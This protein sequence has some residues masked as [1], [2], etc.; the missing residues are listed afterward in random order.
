MIDPATLTI[1]EGEIICPCCVDG[2]CYVGYADCDA[3]PVN[4]KDDDE[5][6]ELAECLL[7]MGTAII[8]ENNPR[9]AWLKLP[10]D[11]RNKREAPD[12]D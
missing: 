1:G 5:E 10:Y 2:A 9:L 8:R 4:R 12:N 3:L 6:D 7:C 11:E